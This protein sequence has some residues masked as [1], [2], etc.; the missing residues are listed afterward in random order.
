MG[1]AE[2]LMKELSK[3]IPRR[4]MDSRFV[5]RYFVG[6]GIDIGGKPDPLA[7]YEEF[8]PMMKSVKIWDLEDG[9]AQFMTTVH[10][11]SFDFVH[12]SHTLEHMV[13][14][15][16]ALENWIR[17]TKP[18]GHLIISIPDEDLYEQGNFNEKFN[19]YHQWSF[20]IW[21]THSWSEKSI[22][23][24]E[25]ITKL[26]NPIEVLAIS[27][28]DSTYRYN[29][30]RYDQTRTPIGESAIEI[31]LRKRLIEEIDEGGRLPKSIAF[32]KE[33]ECHY[34]QYTLDQ[35]AAAEKYPE[36]FGETK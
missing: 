26:G 30:P 28:Q 13:D 24:L 18:G 27:L 1:R 2:L 11:N 20:T 12:S 6:N 17:I 8:F 29:L 25:L 23:L 7:L 15:K 5:S 16:V 4:L 21:K 10:E 31:I 35:R 19:R 34:L 22:N 32:P 9:D 33:L 36:P 14:P 3:S